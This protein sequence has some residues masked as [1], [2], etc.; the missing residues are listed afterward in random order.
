MKLDEILDS[1]KIENPTNEKPIT[2]TL[3]DGG[4]LHV[5]KN[6]LNSLY[7]KIVKYGIK[8]NVNVQL[9]ERMGEYHPLVVDIDIKYT[10][11]INDR[12]YTDETVYQIISFL[13]AKLTDYIDL[14][15]KSNFG[16]IWIMEKDKP[17]PCSTNKKYKSKDGIHITF[18]KIIISKKTYKKL[19]HELK[20]EKQIQSIFNDTCTITPDNEE[21]TLFDGCFTSWQPYGCGKKNES[22]YKLTKVFSIDEGDN[23]IQVDEDSFE[24]YFSDDLTILKTMSMC[25]HEKETIQYLPSLQSIVDKGLKNLTSSNT[26]GFVMVNNNDIYGQVPCYV[27]NN[28]IIN[29]YKIVEEEELKLIQ[30]LVSCLSSERASDYSKWL[31]VGL[32]LHNLNNEKLLPD[33]KKFSSQDESYDEHICD[34]KWNS[35]NNNH[36]GSKLGMGSLR[37]WAKNDDEKEYDKVLRENLG[38]QIKKSISHGPDAHHLLALVIHKY[39]ENQFICV[40][41]NDDWYFFN[42][43][44]W[45]HTKKANEL[46]KRIHKDI[47]NLYHEYSKDYKDKRESCEEGSRDYKYYDDSHSR[48]CD[49]QKKLLQEN[50]VNTIIGALRHIFYKEDIMEDFDSNLDLIGFENG[51]YDLKSNVFREGRPE[52]YV[53]LSTKVSIPVSKEDLPLELDQLVPKMESIPNY[54]LLF[55]GM[56]SFISQIIP[57]EE[58]R[59]YAMRFI[60][61]CLSGENRDEGFYIWTGSGGNGKSKL[62]D[63][64]KL[65]LGQYACNLPVTVLTQK[66]KASGAA[67]P[68][69]AITRGK[70]WVY[71]QEPDVK[72]TL[73]VG[74]M[75]EITGNDVIQARALYKEPF[76]FVPQFKLIMMCN[77]LPKI[78]SNDDGTWRRLEAVPF[79]SRFVKMEDVDESN[80]RYLMEDVK[81]KLPHWVIPFLTVLFKEWRLYDVE[82]IS[83]PDSVK[84]KTSAY[85]NE[86]DIIGQWI[87]AQCEPAD[88]ELCADGVTE[89]APSEL[90]NLYIDFKDWCEE[91]EVTKDVVPDKNK[92]KEALKRWQA[93]SKYGLKMGRKKSDKQ[94]NGCESSPKFNLVVV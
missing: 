68:E 29:P 82:G 17:Y 8:K 79:T 75:K 71:L 80:H 56:F 39:Y 67:N 83:I 42:G 20:K 38:S 2:H 36:E 25:Y 55:D 90:K 50:Y 76:E 22:Y 57:D 4:K 10:N 19:I 91:E 41:I 73:N 58:L 7:K 94:P 26:S 11:E 65:C 13:W 9:V 69:M 1:L 24:T 72:E 28:N 44:R 35:F 84:D 85:R 14:K 30:G 93:N 53:T 54:E 34:Q 21:D 49:F 61:K 87:S 88:H 16:E 66:R 63:L 62:N 3:M 6:K 27:D 77:E 74:E 23:P 47:Y 81:R 64:I 37:W 51:I 5:P 45:K 43:I 89:T 60:S 40:D 18:P 46:K 52:D 86:N 12:Q 92:F 59:D 31:S 70:R 48:C 33:W 78:P 15:D 32:C